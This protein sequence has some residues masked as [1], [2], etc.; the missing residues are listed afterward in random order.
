MFRH[1]RWALPR[2][3]TRVGVDVVLRHRLRPREQS[4]KQRLPPQGRRG[5]GSRLTLFLVG[6][7][8]PFFRLDPLFP[9]QPLL[10]HPLPLLPFFLLP[11]L[12]FFLLLLCPG[13]SS[14]NDFVDDGRYLGGRPRERSFCH[15]HLVIRYRVLMLALFTAFAV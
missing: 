9:L 8:L 2:D 5:P 6:P 14:A 11:L 15:N 12:A 13:L 10:L 4:L 3:L 1:G 7:S